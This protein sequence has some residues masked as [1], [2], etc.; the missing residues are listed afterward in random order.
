MKQQQMQ[1]QAF[2]ISTGLGELAA[3]FLLLPSYS[4]FPSLIL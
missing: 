3:S 1:E 2:N 4:P